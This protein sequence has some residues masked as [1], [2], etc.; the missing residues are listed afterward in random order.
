MATRASE[1][2][3]GYECWL[4]YRRLADPDRLRL[5]RR[6]FQAVL[7]RLVQQVDSAIEWRDVINAYFYRKSGIPMSWVGPS[8]DHRVWFKSLRPRPS[9]QRR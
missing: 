3:S 6:R 9:R 1:S 7:S 5:V 8:T 2:D 4:A